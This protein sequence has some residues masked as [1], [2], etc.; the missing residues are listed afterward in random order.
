M[1]VSFIIETSFSNHILSKNFFLSYAFHHEF[2]PEA[3][4]KYGNA[5]SDMLKVK[6]KSS[7]C[8]TK[9]H[10]MNTYWRVEV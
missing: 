2:K 1:P 5:Y 8:L 7:L 10:A 4:C 3:F 9:H 6:V